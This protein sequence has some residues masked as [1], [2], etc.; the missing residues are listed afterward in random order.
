MKELLRVLPFTFFLPLSLRPSEFVLS[1]SSIVCLIT[2]RS[3]SSAHSLQVHPRVN[4]LGLL[5]IALLVVR[6]LPTYPSLS[7]FP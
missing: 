1:R 4:L 3:F 5:K 6:L 2:I 7:T